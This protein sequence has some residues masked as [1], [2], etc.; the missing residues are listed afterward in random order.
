MEGYYSDRL[1]GPADADVEVEGEIKHSPDSNPFQIIGCGKNISFMSETTITNV[2]VLI[3]PAEGVTK[4]T[5]IRFNYA[6]HFRKGIELRK[7]TRLVIP[8][9]KPFFVYGQ[10]SDAA[11]FIANGGGLYGY[12]A[13]VVGNTQGD[14][15]LKVLNGSY[16]YNTYDF[17]L[18][19]ETSPGRSGSPLYVTADIRAKFLARNL[20]L[21]AS[22]R[23]PSGT[24]SRECCFVTNGVDGEITVWSIHHSGGNDSR[25]VF[26]GGKLISRDKTNEASKNFAFFH[27][28]GSDW[29]GGYPNPH[30][31][32]ESANGHPIDI[33][34]S[35]DRNFSDGYKNRQVNVSGNGGLIKRGA[36]VLTFSIVPYDYASARSKCTLTGPTKVLGGGIVLKDEDYKLGRGA[37]EVADGAFFDVNGIDVEFSGATGEGTLTNSSLEVSTLSLGYGNEDSDLDIAAIGKFAIAKTGSGTLSVCSRMDGFAGDISIYGGT[38]A[39]ASGV[40]LAAGKLAIG[41]DTVLN[42]DEASIGVSHLSVDASSDTTSIGV[43]RPSANGTLEVSGLLPGVG[44]IHELP[45]AVGS[46]EDEDNFDAWTVVLNGKTKSDARIY[47][48][49]G[50]L[51]VSTSGF[52]VRIR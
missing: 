29:S 41:K 39:V 26:D 42:A 21:L 36:G 20:L 52:S 16:F 6:A 23:V 30:M 51:H 28:T 3:L 46:V 13:P 11:D 47:V 38:V 24:E 15:N 4:R 10:G 2:P 12:K 5:D 37:L 50:R 8:D 35:V 18:G 44:N 22:V 1:A 31:M 43:L 9:G 45:V 27:A 19:Q 49:N 7:Y 40:R 32:V 17:F 25:I 14:A 34:T 33:E 48:L